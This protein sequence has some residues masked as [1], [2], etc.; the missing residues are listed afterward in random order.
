MDES[1]IKRG[2]EITKKLNEKYGNIFNFVYRKRTWNENEECYMGWERKRGLLNQLNE[3]LLG[4]IKNPFR[5]NT[6]ENA[7]LQDIKYIITLDAD[8]DLTLKSGL[9]LIGAM[10]HVLNIPI[11]NEQEDLVVSGHA[12]IQP[13]VGIGLLESRNSVFTQI[14][15]GEGGTDSYTN[16][17]SNLYQDNF[18]EGIFTGKGI[19]DLRVFSKV[20]NK[21]IKENTVLSH[22][23]LEGSYLRCGLASDVVLM[24]GY[25]SNYMSFRTRLYRWIRGDYQILPWLKNRIEITN[26]EIKRNPLNLLSK[27]KI[28]SNIVRSKQEIAVF[29]LILFICASLLFSNFYIFII[30]RIVF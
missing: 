21:E 3:Y 17:I 9:E 11:L 8:T 22:D 20:L 12:I 28:F 2:I 30:S 15:A 10:A 23:L 18:D 16:V 14:Y 6:M 4:N 27:Y 24:D 29:M 25:P 13:R 26:G 7:K 5:I 1:I 19:Y